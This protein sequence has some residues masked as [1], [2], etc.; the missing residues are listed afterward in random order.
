MGS[1]VIPPL[2]PGFVLDGGTPPL[3]PG[4]VLDDEKK[5]PKEEFGPKPTGG[6][7]FWTGV[8]SP[9]AGALQLALDSPLSMQF[10]N[11]V[12]AKGLSDS[13]TES[14]KDYQARRGEDAKNTDWMRVA[15]EVSNPLTFVSAPLKTATTAGRIGQSAL[16]GGLFGLAR[17]GATGEERVA[18]AAKGAVVGA[19]LPGGWELAKL[20]GRGGR[21]LF[22]GVFNPEAAAGRIS[23]EVSG[24]KVD[25]VIEALSKAEQGQTAQQAAV[26]AGSAKFSALTEIAA[27]K[28]PDEYL[29]AKNLQQEGRE[30]A[31]GTV[32][33]TGRDLEAAIEARAKNARE[34]YSPEV[35]G[36]K[37]DPRSDTSIWNAKVR[38][39][40]KR[41]AESANAD[42]YPVPG[43]PKLPGTYS[44]AFGKN[45]AHEEAFKNAY[46]MLKDTVGVENKSLAALLDR[47]SIQDALRVAMRGAQEKG[48]YFPTKSGEKFTV[49]NIQRMK[50][51][52]DDALNRPGESA[53][54]RTVKGE[55]ADT[56]QALV[57]W[58]GSRSPEWKKARL[59]FAE[60]SKPI[61]QMQVGQFLEKKVKDALD[62][63]EMPG[64]FARAV[65]D[66]PG[67]IKKAG[68]GLPFNKKLEDVLTPE[69][70]S[71]INSLV[72]QYQT[73]ALAKQQAGAGLDATARQIGDLSHI[74]GTGMLNRYV[75]LAT[76]GLRKVA[77]G[78]TD[79]AIEAVATLGRDPAKFAE[80]MR[81]A[82]PYERQEIVDL[83][84][85]QQARA[86]GITAAQD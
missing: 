36:Q 3:P 37:V 83:L 86:L 13:I 62:V 20:L 24:K 40:E 25:D 57:D 30:K 28:Q 45:E 85:Q 9:V 65:E 31:I 82:K 46:Q 47:P 23:R 55:V 63:K 48:S 44:E 51:A 27:K 72:K 50:M 49:E 73:D 22:Q 4:F 42:F 11:P 32:A 16:I 8:K 56:R 71:V 53:L 5:K 79:K 75:T 39:A 18:D 43:Q 66:A 70:M 21:N 17:P 29:A 68:T 58:L 84:M 77:S 1:S 2:P 15:G 7:S 52:L 61:N 59:A 74:Q 38:D 64:V 69:Q 12:L 76:S 60:D 14:E 34:N 67:T 35:M 41:T 78:S 19:L 10:V 6:E 26:P 33:K 80:V 81:K 54:D